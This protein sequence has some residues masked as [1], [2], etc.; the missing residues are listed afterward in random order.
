MMIVWCDRN[1]DNGYCQLTLRMKFLELG[2]T[3]ATKYNL[4]LRLFLF[5]N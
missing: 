4:S 1:Y 5:D 3:S 2:I